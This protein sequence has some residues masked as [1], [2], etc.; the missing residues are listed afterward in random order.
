MDAKDKLE[1]LASRKGGIAPAEL[2]KSV[3]A[4]TGKY[5]TMRKDAG[6][7]N[8]ALEE[9]KRIER[10]L[11]PQLSAWHED[12]SG[13]GIRLRD[14]IEADGQLELS[15]IIATAALCRQESRGGHYRKDY[16]L[17]DDENWLKNIILEKRG[18]AISC[19]IA[20]V[21]KA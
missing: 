11:L 19:R 15:Q 1:T 12:E 6:G 21:V 9:L 17:Q 5:L 7:L 10:D 20:P 16:P 2:K 18:G 13:I 14:A 3:Q 4:V 8:K